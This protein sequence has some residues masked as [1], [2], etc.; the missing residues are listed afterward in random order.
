MKKTAIF[1]IFILVVGSI[2]GT[3]SYFIFFYNPNPQSTTKYVRIYVNSTIYGSLQTEINQYDQDVKNQ[4]YLTSIIS[5]SDTNVSNLR[6]DL[7]NSYN[8]SLVGAVLIGEMPYALYDDESI[9]DTELAYP[10]DLLLM[11]LDGMIGDMSGDGDFDMHVNGTGDIFPEIWIGRINPECLNNLAVSYIQTYKDYFSRNHA[12]RTGNLT[13]PDNALLY[14]DDD[15]AHLQSAMLNDFNTSG[16]SS[17]TN[18]YNSTIT[19]DIDYETNQLTNSSY[20]WVHVMV[21]S[22]SWQQ[23]WG[24]AGDGTQGI[25]N[26]TDINSIVTQPLFYNLFS[27]SACDI[28][29]T[30]NL[31][32]QYL[33]SNNTL[34]VIGSTKTGGMWMI[35][36]FYTPLNQGKTIGEAFRLW[37]WNGLHG[38]SDIDSKGM[39]ILGDP[40]LTK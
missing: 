14:I 16:Y 1:L 37:W 36:Y 6:G 15:W 28:G 11:D 12:Y 4:G 38:P 3:I 17:I 7:I 18:I 24:P 30:N 25:T 19:T 29:Y 32:T 27:C 2:I 31:G 39:I 5:W 20:E 26:N 22:F 10:C 8:T 34:A 13:R 35:S 21:H 33:F 40:L 23:Q 9:G